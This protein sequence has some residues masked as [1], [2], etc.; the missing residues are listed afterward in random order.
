M[1][2]PDGSSSW[3]PWSS[4]SLFCGHE[5]QNIHRSLPGKHGSWGA[6]LGESDWDDILV[7]RTEAHRRSNWNIP[8]GQSVGTFFLKSAEDTLSHFFFFF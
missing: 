4:S 5:K 2:L 3:D 7:T 8:T 6:G 1:G